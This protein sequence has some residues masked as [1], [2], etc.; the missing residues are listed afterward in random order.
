MKKYI[1]LA[2]T[3]PKDTV[4]IYSS[5]LFKISRPINS[6]DD[7][8]QYLFGWMEHPESADIALVCDMDQVIPVHPTKDISTLAQMLNSKVTPEELSALTGYMNQ[9]GSVK[10]GDI[11]PS[12]IRLYSE[13]EM[14]ELGWFPEIQ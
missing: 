9:H 7:V 10:F 4:K 6:P 11:V 5:E 13:E 8:T 12:T 14:K 3:N 1:I 2:E